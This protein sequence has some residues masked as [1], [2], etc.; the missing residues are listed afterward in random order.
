MKHYSM[1]NP[2]L[3]PLFYQSG[4]ITIK[5]YDTARERYTLA[6]PNEEVRR[7]FVQ[8]LKPYALGPDEYE[9]ALSPDALSDDLDAGDVNSA[10]SL[11]QSLLSSISYA[12]G[13]EPLLERKWRNTLYVIFTLL[14]LDVRCEVHSVMGR[15]DC[16]V[17]TSDYIYVFEFKVD[18]PAADALAQI[19][20][21]GYATPY[22]ADKRTVVAVGVS[23][24]TETRTIADWKTA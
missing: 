19:V 14:G 16:V 15:A 11:L 4:Y 3:I 6:F 5:A 23:F 1:E 22:T 10:M 7:G 24:S 13:R 18:R 9:N 17:K 20:E 2:G 21:K 12:E 8:S